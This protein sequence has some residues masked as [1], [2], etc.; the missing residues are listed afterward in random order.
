MTRRFLSL[1]AAA[2][3]I[4]AACQAQATPTVGPTATPT[5]PPA[6][7]PTAP[8]A[9]ATPEPTPAG[10][11]PI[12]SIGAGEGELN[13]IIWPG[14]AEEGLNEPAYDWIHPFETETGCQVTTKE[15][16]T[17]DE[18]V[19]LLRQ[20]GGTVYD[21][22]SASGDASNRLI[23]GGDLAA[24]DPS[25]FPDFNDIWPPLQSPAHNTVDGVHYG[26]SHGWGANLLMWNTDVVTT[27]PD[28]WSVVF[29]ANSPYKGKVTAYDSPIYI[30]DAALYLSFARPDLGITDP[31]ELT[32]AQLDAS[33]EILKDQ[34]TVVGKY[35]SY[36]GDQ[37]T[38]FENGDS[39]LGTT[40]PYQ[41]TV[42]K[43]EEVP[44]EAG[45]PREGATGWADSW[46]MS[47]N[48]KHPNC[49]LMWMAWMITPETQQQVA[50]HFGEA[51][52]NIKACDLIETSPGPWG[53]QGFCADQHASDPD[54]AARIKFWKTPSTDCGDARGKTCTDYSVWTQ[55][56]AEIKG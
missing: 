26:V 23:E 15:A 9:T 54:Y 4:A 17:S 10:P 33:V 31:Y 50:E 22:L 2:M 1:A 38:D 14:Y 48:A 24:V 27:A 36:Y 42:L 3:L 55:K 40:W 5:A 39:V 49:M 35:W 46:M 20:G 56:W 44:I 47:A 18:M 6:A 34:K 51:P 13:I 28:S 53:Y 43:G 32:Q 41:V 29:D 37:I 16:A 12:A 25:I 7:T 8:P 45:L 21:G 11:T 19:Q 30:A 52:A